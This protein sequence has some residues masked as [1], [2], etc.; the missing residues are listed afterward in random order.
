MTF[1]PLISVIVPVYNGA[2]YV[3]EAIESILAQSYANYEIVVVNDGSTDDGATHEA[4]QPYLDR[5]KY[6]KQE[7]GG[8]SSA[9]NT[10]IENMNGEY[11]GWLSHDDLFL[12]HKLESQ[13]KILGA[14]INRAVVLYSDYG[15]VNFDKEHQY[16]VI[17]DSYML[18]NSSNHM[19]VL[20]GCLNGCTMLIHRDI[21]EQCGQFDLDLRFTQDYEMWD[22]ISWKYPL[23]H[24]SDI[25]VHQR[26][27][28]KQDSNRPEALLECNNL[29][30]NMI[31]KRDESTRKEI[32]GSPLEFLLGMQ[33][34]L[35]QTPYID[36]QSFVATE[37][38]NLE[39][40]RSLDVTSPAPENK[41]LNQ[42][43]IERE[44]SIVNQNE[45][46]DV[47]FSK[48]QDIDLS[49]LTIILDNKDSYIHGE[50]SIHVLTSIKQKGFEIIFLCDESEKSEQIS[51]VLKKLSKNSKCYRY[52]GDLSK[53][54][55]EAIALAK[56]NYVM[57]LATRD[58]ILP[59]NLSRQLNQ[60]KQNAQ[61]VSYASYISF[62]KE[63][64]ERGVTVPSHWLGEMGHEDI[65][66]RCAVNLSTMIF[67]K[68]VFTE[69]VKPPIRRLK[70]EIEFLLLLRI[71][72][73]IDVF[74]YVTIMSQTQLNLVPLNLTRSLDEVSELLEYLDTN[75]VFSD[76]QLAQSYLRKIHS[77]LY[78]IRLENE[79][80]NRDVSINTTL[81][82]AYK[83][84][85]GAD[86]I[87][88]NAGLLTVDTL[89]D[90]SQ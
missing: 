39:N 60:M 86:K 32:S 35:S 69:T 15:I 90:Q 55:A 73:K 20:R 72:H 54:R 79:K 70:S 48:P 4:I 38:A 26:V 61:N 10:G 85:L 43:P 76:Y 66:G 27:H 31:K 9:L 33:K 88:G 78:E 6:I 2:D 58:V 87:I 65:I 62:C 68:K 36:A 53:A 11:F 3:G 46:E 18:N 75:E 52:T 42:R 22:R 23:I 84:P 56:N 25:T 24:Q 19:P 14:L 64:S 34:F 5:V 50:K 51:R 37:I 82:E 47:T 40:P 80:L 45:G 74:E 29:W 89:W 44:G 67:N 1:N 57:F 30:V 13:V 21:F 49:G 77:R 81:M 41:D 16:D 63:I 12:P 17:L 71:A 59:R 7:N 28:E 8:V 83:V